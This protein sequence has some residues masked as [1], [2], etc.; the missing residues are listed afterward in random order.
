MVNNADTYALIGHIVENGLE[1]YYLG[2]QKI[3]K[4][5]WV[6]RKAEQEKA[7]K[8]KAGASPPHDG[9]SGH[10]SKKVMK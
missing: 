9:G 4:N 3:S 6:L 5:M 1:D 7:D 2:K 10:D 8:R